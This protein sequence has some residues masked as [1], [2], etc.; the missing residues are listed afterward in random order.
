MDR[1]RVHVRA[2]GDA[3]AILL[4]QVSDYPRPPDVAPDA[5]T[6][7]F[8]FLGHA[9]RGADFMESQFGVRVKVASPLDDFF[10]DAMGLLQ[11]MGPPGC[12]FGRSEEHTSELQSPTKLVCRLLL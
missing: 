2:D 12:E 5:I 3:H 8:Q 6:E 4:P 1:Q 11:H 10:L 7:L 9:R